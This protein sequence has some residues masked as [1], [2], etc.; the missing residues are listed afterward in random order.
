MTIT[1]NAKTRKTQIIDITH[2]ARRRLRELGE[3]RRGLTVFVGGKVTEGKNRKSN[4]VLCIDQAKDG[5]MIGELFIPEKPRFNGINTTPKGGKNHETQSEE[6]YKQEVETFIRKARKVLEEKGLEGIGLTVN[7]NGK[8][9][10]RGGGEEDAL[11]YIRR[12]P[13]GLEA[14]L[15]IPL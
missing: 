3:H 5:H 10:E 2:K 12:R 6:A 7:I 15:I 13:T 8:T 9:I 1:T 14:D 4:A 11:L